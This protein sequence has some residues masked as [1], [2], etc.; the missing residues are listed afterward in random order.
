MNLIFF[1]QQGAGKGTYA[2]YTEKNYGFKQISTGDL[3]REEAKQQTSLGKKIKETM[4][5][6]ALVDDETITQI[7]EERLKQK[8]VVKGFVLDGYPRTLK[9]AELL[10]ELLKKIGKKIDLVVNYAVT[11]QTS[12]QRLGGRLTCSKCNRIYHTKN[13]PPKVPGIC[14]IDNAPLF[15]REDDKPEAIRKRLG[16]YRKQTKPL[17]EHYK[18]KGLLR[19]IDANPELDVVS[20]RID[21]LFK[22]FIK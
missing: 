1:G 5:S 15:Q 8:D 12:L 4:N 11:D 21:E 18:K 13:I 19:E 16:E 2:Q 20:K 6:G 9:Q 14:D 22:K 3:L 10:D 17:I 7:L